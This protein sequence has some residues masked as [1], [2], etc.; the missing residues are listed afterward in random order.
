MT[1]DPPAV[2]PAVCPLCG[3]PNRCG[4][5][6]GAAS[7]WCFTATIPDRVLAELPAEAV[8]VACVCARCVVAGGGEAPDA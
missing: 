2:D 1:A 4:A 7:C 8:G 3:E 6:A 5:A